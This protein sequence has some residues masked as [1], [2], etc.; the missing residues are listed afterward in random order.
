[1]QS[2]EITPVA[3]GIAASGDFEHG[4]LFASISTKELIAR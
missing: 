4:L 3:G 1:L 2:K